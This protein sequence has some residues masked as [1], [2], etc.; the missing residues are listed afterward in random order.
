MGSAL[1]T[2]GL[3]VALGIIMFGLESG[4]QKILDRLKKQQTLEQITTA[5]KN[6]KKA[7]IEIVTRVFGLILSSIAVTGLVVAIKLSFGLH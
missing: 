3:P 4:S 6:A 7:G 1:T 2:I 5:V